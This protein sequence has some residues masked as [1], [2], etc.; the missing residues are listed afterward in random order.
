MKVIS[1]SNQI[2]NAETSL[3]EMDGVH[4]LILESRGGTKG[5]KNE[6]NPDYI[7]ALDV[8]L[9]RLRGRRIEAL[10]AFVCSAPLADWPLPKK[11]LIIDGN[12]LVPLRKYDPTDLRK[13]ICTAQ[14]SI[15]KNSESKGGNPTKRILLAGNLN[16][17]EWIEV[18]S[19]SSQ[20]FSVSES[21]LY[22]SSPSFDPGDISESK[23]RVTRSIVARRGQPKFR[24]Q[25]L[26]AYSNT[27]AISGCQVVELLEAAHIVPYNGNATNHI[28]N[29]ILIRSDIHTLFDLG[30][31]GISSEYIINIDSKL[32]NTE[33]DSYQGSTIMLPATKKQRPSKKALGTRPL[34]A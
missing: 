24:K 21:D 1:E 5:S 18:V 26:K 17:S 34:P 28:T 23:E 9:S 31:L 29:G 20:T 33:Y 8:I 25:L 14:Q 27:C 11:Q 15:K 4:G 19:G 6:R 22:T 10:R 32:K 16:D 12:E 30:L 2:L 7:P 13:K 3:F